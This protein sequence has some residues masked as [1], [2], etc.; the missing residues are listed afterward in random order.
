[1]N[2][3]N[4]NTYIKKTYSCSRRWHCK[5]LTLVRWRLH[6][7]D[8]KRRKEKENKRKCHLKIYNHLPLNQTCVLWISHKQQTQI[9]S[10]KIIDLLS[11]QSPS[12]FFSPSLPLSWSAFHTS[13]SLSLA[14]YGKEILS[15]FLIYHWQRTPLIGIVF[16]SLLLHRRLSDIL[17]AFPHVPAYHMIF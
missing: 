12:P 3:A 11:T 1:M 9:E 7:R 4:Q 15:A 10:K 13:S 5:N 14:C 16:K 2:L 17:H 6:F 8:C